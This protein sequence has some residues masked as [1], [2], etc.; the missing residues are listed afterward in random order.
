MLRNFYRDDENEDMMEKPLYNSVII[1]TYLDYL[2]NNYPGINCK[3]LMEYAGIAD[4]EVEDRGHWLTQT[5][6]NRFN[7]YASRATANPNMSRQAGRY[8]ASAKSSVSSILRQSLAGFLSPAVA[9]WA[10]E[11]I[12]TRISR[13]LSFKSRSLADNKIELIA[14]SNPG[15]KEEPFQCQNR[16][17]MFEAVAEIFTG[18]YATIEHPE[19]Q[20]AGGGCC[21]YIITWESPKS[22]IM[23]KVG[24][25][26]L[27]ASLVASF[28][29]L[30]FLPTNHWLIVTLSTLLFSTALLLWGS[31]LLNR[32]M[33]ANLIQQG[34]SSEDMFTQISLRYTESLMIQEIG[35]A[36]SSIHNP[37]ELLKFITEAL[38]KRLMFERSMVM[39]VN[40]ER[41]KLTYSAGHGFT[42]HE[43]VVLRNLSF[44][45][46]D[47]ESKGFFYLTYS[48]QK[49]FILDSKAL[50]EANLSEASYQLIKDLGVKSFICVPILYQKKAEGVLAVDISNLC[51]KTTQSDVTLLV[52]VAQQIGISL[53]NAQAHKKALE[54]E[55]RL[56]NLSENAPDIIYQLDQEGRIKYV[57]PAWEELLGHPPSDL[58]GKYLIDFLKQED[59]LAFDATYQNILKDKSRVRDK[60]FTI[61]NTRGLPRQIALSGTPD[62][63]AE[64][65][66]IGMIGTIKDASQLRRHGNTASLYLKND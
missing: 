30:H 24:S 40:P 34:R 1:K 3:E 38:H 54:N 23:K 19:C 43:E 56:R 9:Y 61:F 39:L 17:G 45:L 28:P 7:E 48:L 13:H 2:R 6:V 41:T 49:T 33:T 5:Q 51:T 8:I 14:T 29:L 66:V 25:Y 20:H 59:R 65:H 15:V 21:R 63:D 46:T 18:K 37:Q 11:K 31:L 36:I 64:G 57:N 53:I 16:L 12:S 32:E 52:A 60:Y 22:L 44:S 27:A 50:R 62:V 47:P 35:E 26:A 10:V 4:F 42:P 58:A 55:Q